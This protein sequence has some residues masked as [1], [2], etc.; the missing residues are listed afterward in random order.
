MS[1]EYKMQKVNSLSTLNKKSTLYPFHEIW[2]IWILPMAFSNHLNVILEPFICIIL[3][4]IKINVSHTKTVPNDFKL[5]HKLY[6]KFI[7]LN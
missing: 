2:L 3:T 4:K 7:Y 5:D 6:S 1:I